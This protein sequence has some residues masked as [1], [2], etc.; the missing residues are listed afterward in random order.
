MKTNC[1]K[2]NCEVDY[3][4][5]RHPRK[6]RFYLEFN[7]CKFGTFCRY[8]HETFSKQVSNEVENLKHTIECL[9]KDIVKKDEEIAITDM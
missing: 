1:V 7:Y 5:L 4:P 6:C 9:R 3:C 8:K 2:K